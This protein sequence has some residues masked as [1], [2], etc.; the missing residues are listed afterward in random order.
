MTDGEN[1]AG[2]G[3]AEF[4][5]RHRA[6][7]AAAAAVPTFPVPFGEADPSALERAARATGGRVV[8]A[9]LSS[10]TDAFKEIRGCH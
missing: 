3:Y 6:L 9:R 2:L 4:L 1:N 8:D 7:G 10:L 5:R